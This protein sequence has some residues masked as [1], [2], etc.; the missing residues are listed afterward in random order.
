MYMLCLQLRA[1]GFDVLMNPSQPEEGSK[2]EA[3]RGHM[4]RDRGQFPIRSGVQ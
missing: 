2:G 4:V 1:I 3:H